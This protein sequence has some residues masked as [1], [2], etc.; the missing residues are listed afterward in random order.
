M[1]GAAGHDRGVR[2]RCRRVLRVSDRVDAVVLASQLAGGAAVGDRAPGQTERAERTD[3]DEI[4][5]SHRTEMTTGTPG[6]CLS[7]GMMIQR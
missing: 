5:P 3:L 1:R 4:A 7:A 6:T 2:P